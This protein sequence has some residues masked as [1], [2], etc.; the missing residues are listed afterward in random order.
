MTKFVNYIANPPIYTPLDKRDSNGD[1]KNALTGTEMS[2]FVHANWQK[3]MQQLTDNSNVN[4]YYGNPSVL[5]NSDFYWNRGIATPV[6]QGSGNGAFFSEK[7]QVQGA[8]VATYTITQEAFP[9]ND[10]DQI[11]STT[12][13]KV[14]A[15][16]FTTGDFYLY[17]RQ[18]GSQFLRR[19]QKRRLNLSLLAYNNTETATLLNFEVFYHFDPTNA[20]YTG[21]A[22]FLQPGSNELAGVIDTP[23]IG[24]TA[25]GAGAYVEF[26][27]RFGN[28]GVNKANFNLTYIKAEM[29]DQPTVLYVDHALEKTRI[30]NS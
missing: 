7:W 21:Q 28:L 16:D 2:G 22:I 20:T 29:A 25:V 18:T 9:G 4:N 30:D 27:L 6:T 10:S 26:R 8:A 19:Y 3:W 5:L 17:Q 11:G 12:Y 24:D 15:E 13:I 14:D 1:Q 23:Y